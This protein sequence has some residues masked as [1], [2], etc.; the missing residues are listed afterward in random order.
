VFGFTMAAGAYVLHR[1]VGRKVKRYVRDRLIPAAESNLE[2]RRRQQVELAERH[3]D[4]RVCAVDQ[5]AFGAG[6]SRVLPV[7]RLLARRPG[8][9]DAAMN[10]LVAELRAP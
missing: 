3:P 2:N 1:T 5:V 10:A 4:L 7:T 8:D 6:G 9:V